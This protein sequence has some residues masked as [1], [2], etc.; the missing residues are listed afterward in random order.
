MDHLSPQVQNA[1]NGTSSLKRRR[2]SSTS[3]GSPRELGQMRSRRNT[4]SGSVSASF[5]GSGSGIHFVRTVRR[6][7]ARNTQRQNNAGNE[8]TDS[9]LVPGEDDQ[10]ESPSTLWRADEISFPEQ[11]PRSGQDSQTASKY[12]F[13][14]L[15]QWSRSYFDHWHPP[16]PFLRAPTFLESLEKAA[17]DGFQRLD[18]TETTIIRA[19]MSISL[20]DRRQLPKNGTRPIPAHLVFQS[21]DDAIMALQPLIILPSSLPALQ[22]IVSVQIFL[23]SMLR[24]NAAS[25]IGG[26]IIR[27]SFHLGLHRCPT[28]FEQFST[29]DADIRRRLFWSIYSLERYISQSLGLPLDLRDDDIDVCFPDNEIHLA[30]DATQGGQSSRGS[31]VETHLLLPTFLAKHGK[32]K[33]LIL[34][35]RNKSVLHSRTDP[36]EVS[37]IDAEISKWWNEAQEL[38]DPLGQEGDSSWNDD[39]QPQGT[40]QTHGRLPRSLRSSHKLFLL[41]Q[42]HESVILLSRPVITSGYNT[43]AF[44]AAMHKC[45]GA[46]KAI[47]MNVYRHILADTQTI[48]GS[49]QKDH[50]P[51]VWPGF[52]WL[53]WQSGLILLYAAYEGHYSTQVAQK[54]SDRCVAILERLALRGNFWPLACASAIKE[55][56]SALK[57]KTLEE[58]ASRQRGT[59]PS[60]RIQLPNST[61]RSTE[62]QTEDFAR[63]NSSSIQHLNSASLATG[64]DIEPRSSTQPADLQHFRVRGDNREE[65]SPASIVSP[66]VQSTLNPGFNMPYDGSAA[67][68]SG[69]PNV[70]MQEGFYPPQDEISS[71]DIWAGTSNGLLFPS[72]HGDELYDIFQLMDASYLVS[73][74]TSQL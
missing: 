7:F 48:S 23:I 20:A 17:G 34:E 14:D 16:F 28:R 67:S 10:L 39:S 2:Q 3:A 32:I 25:R 44:A 64:I 11:E 73:G 27:M 37:I 1:A 69:Q 22:A 51:L 35:L 61:Y 63:H 45:I 70:G 13:N 56:Q 31:Q 68:A 38:L 26:L 66:S 65:N 74:Q 33:G 62:L 58:T 52:V 21:T 50:N 57:H 46:S 12:T 5:V 47:I 40:P 60:G 71:N 19:L 30:S 72:D 54:E 15:V 42:K 53:I 55:L 8:A 18:H 43:T 24:L 9:E 41:V 6:A 4:K 49:I 29:T 36:D 59:M